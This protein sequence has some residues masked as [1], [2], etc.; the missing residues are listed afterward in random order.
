MQ[1]AVWDAVSVSEGR[2]LLGYASGGSVTMLTA[3]AGFVEARRALRFVGLDPRL[4]FYLAIHK[5]RLVTEPG[6]EDVQYREQ[7]SSPDSH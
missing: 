6:R 4:V 5:L 2:A 1:H 3:R 7:C